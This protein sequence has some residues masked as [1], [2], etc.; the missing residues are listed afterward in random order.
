MQGKPVPGQNPQGEV[1]VARVAIKIPPIWRRNVKIWR[2]QVDAQFSN[3]PV[4]SEL[5]KYNYVLASLDSDVAELISDFLLKPL[6]ANPYKDLMDRLQSEFEISEGRKDDT[7][8][9]RWVG[10]REMSDEDLHPATREASGP[11]V[12]LE[13]VDLSM[14]SSSTPTPVP[15]LLPI[16]KFIAARPSPHPPGKS[17]TYRTSIQRV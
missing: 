2:M 7:V 1:H 5:T 12:Q 14:K 13:P 3:S 6:S 17:L 4:T 8:G 10:G 16:S 11:P 9:K 15:A